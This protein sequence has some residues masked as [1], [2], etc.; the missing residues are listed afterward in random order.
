MRVALP[1]VAPYD[2]ARTR[3]IVAQAAGR[4]LVIAIH[5][6]HRRPA[7]GDWLRALLTRRPDAIVVELGVPHP[8]LD[9]A[10]RIDSHGA[11]RVCGQAAAEALAGR[12]PTCT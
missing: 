7:V 10:V 11:A 2:A 8:G 3:S 5:D 6:A 4:P 12:T 1:A 9:G